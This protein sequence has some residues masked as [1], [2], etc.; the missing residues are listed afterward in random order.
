VLDDTMAERLYFYGPEMSELVSLACLSK[1]SG[2]GSEKAL[3]QAL[4]E[5]SNELYGELVALSQRYL[6]AVTTWDAVHAYRLLLEY[7]DRVGRGLVQAL[8]RVT[9]RKAL[10]RLCTLV[11][12]CRLSVLK[13]PGMAQEVVAVGLKTAS[14]GLW[15]AW[16][17]REMFDAMVAVEWRNRGEA[18]GVRAPCKFPDAPAHGCSRGHEVLL[19]SP[20]RSFQALAMLS[21]FFV[22]SQHSVAW[23]GTILDEEYGVGKARMLWWT[24]DMSDEEAVEESASVEAG[25]VTAWRTQ[26]VQRSTYGLPGWWR[27]KRVELRSPEGL[28]GTMDFDFVVHTASGSVKDWPWGLIKIRRDTGVVPKWFTKVLALP[29]MTYAPNFSMSDVVKERFVL[30]PNSEQQKNLRLEE[31]LE[32][33]VSA[34]EAEKGR[35]LFMSKGAASDPKVYMTLE[36][37]LFTWIGHGVFV[38]AAALS[39]FVLNT[40]ATRYGGLAFFAIALI[41][42]AYPMI[43]WR[44]R[45]AALIHGTDN[46]VPFPDFLGPAVAVLLLVTMLGVVIVMTALFGS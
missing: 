6:A 12:A 19:V 1:K 33:G 26:L 9:D 16:L 14:S 31:G 46:I 23:S 44:L 38:G 42:C 41:L 11:Q 21:R 8:Q 27:C 29:V 3:V 18:A 5:V 28:S 45:L 34:T 13:F 30:D 4:E 36:R 22:V 7:N 39:L 43:R 32:S 2:F 24:S 37:T 20:G 15:S 40:P 10:V 35:V 17:E 25:G